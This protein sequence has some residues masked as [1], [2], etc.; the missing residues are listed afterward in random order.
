MGTTRIR[1]SGNP[2]QFGYHVVR[3]DYGKPNSGNYEA[4]FVSFSNSYLQVLQHTKVR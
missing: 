1:K 2:I 3:I 4:L